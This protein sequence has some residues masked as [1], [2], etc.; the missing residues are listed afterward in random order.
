MKYKI[1]AYNI[2][3]LGGREKQEDALFPPYG[4]VNDND[5]LFIVCDGMGGH[6]AGEVASKAVC[7][8]MSEYIL[9][10]V[11]DP[12]GY[13]VLFEVESYGRLVGMMYERDI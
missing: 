8:S 13:H 12:E 6:S 10:N 1:K 9:N 2:W 4:Q 5:R 3:E 7:D 11:P